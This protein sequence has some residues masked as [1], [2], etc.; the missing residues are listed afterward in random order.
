[1]NCN[2]CRWNFVS[3]RENRSSNEMN[4]NV[5]RLFLGAQNFDIIRF[6]TYRTACKLRFIQKKLNCTSCECFLPWK[7]AF[8][9]SSSP[10][11]PIKCHRISS[12]MFSNS[13]MRTSFFD[14]S[15]HSSLEDLSHF[16]L[17][18]SQ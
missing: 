18:Q 16:D 15:I 1:M 9:S 3:D 5:R 14:L 17:H 10:S 7:F 2:N 11:R 4:E 8:L 13:H 12:R 6:S